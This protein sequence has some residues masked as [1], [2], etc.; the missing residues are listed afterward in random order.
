MIDISVVAGKAHVPVGLLVCVCYF[1]QEARPLYSSQACSPQHSA[2]GLYDCE[3][4][5]FP[6]MD[7]QLR[8]QRRSKDTLP[9]RTDGDGQL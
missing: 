4:N 2:A 8:A 5:V 6:S 1:R 7:K 9:A 3:L